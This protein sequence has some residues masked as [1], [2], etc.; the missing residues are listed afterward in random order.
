MSNFDYVLGKTFGILLVFM[1]LY[2]IVLSMALIFNV[3]FADIPVNLIAYFWYPV[4][5]S[6]P[7]LVFILGLSF[8]FMVI[9]KNQP[10]TFVILLGYIAVTAFFLS[11]KYY[12]LF[13]YMAYNV[14]LMYSDFVGFGGFE[15]LIIHRGMYFFLGIG[16]IFATILMIKRLPQSRTM[17][18][19]SKLFVVIFLVLGFGL[20]FVYVSKISSSKSLRADMLSLNN[21]LYSTPRINPLSY[22]IDVN[23]QGG[24]IESIA[25]ITF[26]N[27]NDSPLSEYILSLNPGLKVEKIENKN[28]S[29]QFD[30]NLHIITIKPSQPIAVNDVDSIKITYK[31]AIDDRACYLDINEEAREQ[32]YRYWMF[33]VNKRYS[34]IR[35]DYVLLTPENL[36]YPIPGVNFNSEHPEIHP[37]D[38]SNYKLAVKTDPNLTPISQGKKDK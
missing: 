32:N 31:G 26:Q 23:H 1:T 25:N 9:I 17:T 37:L 10:V 3:F 18:G 21:E 22:N 8:L 35:P 13:D 20:G 33:V 27:S 29:V 24:S 38:F 12:H 2:I 28:G 36:W 5:I 30:R 16:C 7:T 15:N 34:F 11:M 19:L 4:L 14:P 6:F